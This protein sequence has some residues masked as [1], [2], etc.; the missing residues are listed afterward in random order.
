MGLKEIKSLRRAVYLWREFINRRSYTIGKENKRIW[1]GIRINTRIHIRGDR[2]RLIVEKGCMV[3][4]TLIHIVGN[5]N[6]IVLHNNAYVSGAEL[7]LEDDGCSLEIGKKTFVGHHSHLACTEGCKMVIGDNC[8][9]SSFV[10]IRTG[11]SHS[12]FDL[13]GKRINYG[14]NVRIGD[15]CWIGQGAKILKGVKLDEDI[16]VSTGAIVTKPFPSKVM[17]G[18]VPAKVLKEDV[19]WSEERVL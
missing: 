12:I 15:H 13:E 4:D 11:D 19:T 3:K 10:Q 14:E 17:V 5:D 18:G 7:W 9:I 8:L 2:N 1:E 16:I 6:T